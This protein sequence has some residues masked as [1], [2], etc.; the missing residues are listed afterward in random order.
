[1]R[2][3]IKKY[4]IAL[5]ALFYETR[6]KERKKEQGELKALHKQKKLFFGI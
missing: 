3:L 5:P 4:S 6:K 2:Q 1:M